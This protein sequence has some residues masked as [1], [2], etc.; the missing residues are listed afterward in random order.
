M[1]VGAVAALGGAGPDGVAA[2]PAFA[3]LVVAHGGDNVI[4]DVAGFLERIGDAGGLLAGKF[5]D[6]VVER[7]ELVRLQIALHEGIV[8]RS[9]GGSILR[10]GR[11]D[12]DGVLAAGGVEKE[13][14]VVA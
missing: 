9:R 14:D 10:G 6:G 1:K 7:H 12:V 11:M 8:S 13:C 5:G 4:V 3:G 2:S